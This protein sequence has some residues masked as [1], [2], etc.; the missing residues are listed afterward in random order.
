MQLP[1]FK[2]KN[3]EYN[4]D[5]TSVYIIILGFLNF[6]VPWLLYFCDIN[7][8]HIIGILMLCLYVVSFSIVAYNCITTIIKYRNGQK[9]TYTLTEILLC[10]VAHFIMSQSLSFY[11]VTNNYV[12]INKLLLL[13]II[14]V[15][16]KETDIVNL[17]IKLFVFYLYILSLVFK[18][19]F[20]PSYLAIDFDPNPDPG[21]I[22]VSMSLAIIYSYNFVT[23]LFNKNT[24]K[25]EI[26]DILNIISVFLAI[27]VPIVYYQMSIYNKQY[28]NIPE[29]IS[30]IFILTINQL[31]CRMKKMERKI[32][33]MYFLKHIIIHIVLHEILLNKPSYVA[34]LIWILYIA[35]SIELLPNDNKN[36]ILRKKIYCCG[37]F[38][39]MHKGHME[40]F[41][42]M[43]K[44]GDVVVGIIDDE[45]VASYKRLPI[46]NHKERCET[47][48]L[49]KY[50][51]EI[52]PNCPLDTT[53]EFM[54]MHN[55]DLVAIGEEYFSPP[56][57]YYEECVK[58]NKYL[59]ISRCEGISSTDLINRIKIRAEHN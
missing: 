9:T 12:Y 46:M 16:T 39:M 56:Y 11:K 40:L 5:R 53:L 49:A 3:K 54:K 13:A 17:Q 36:N 43:N 23:Y 44:Y 41:E 21:N 25:M 48:K 18:I 24:E 55:I 19:T 34:D 27:V 51:T 58:A 22:F 33:T 1:D 26:S 35:I 30:D 52:I 47:V 37:V 28:N 57:K 8:S 2:N 45:T 29:N 20:L 59:V 14:M 38:D 31:I 42:K 6:V 15:Q 10:F 7:Q 50:V 4:T 32:D